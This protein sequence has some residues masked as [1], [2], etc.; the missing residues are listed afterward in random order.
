MGHFANQCLDKKTNATEKPPATVRERPRAV[1]RVF[2]LTTTK[3]TQSGNRIL[4]P[5]VL[6]GKSVLVLFDFGA[7]HS[8][9]SD[10]CVSKL[11][12][13]KSDLDCELLV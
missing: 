4:E 10:A 2:A 5:C 1:G 7:T 3:A 13:E 9:I 11:S 6:F 12:L 8:F